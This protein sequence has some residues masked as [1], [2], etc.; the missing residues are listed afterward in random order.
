MET[1]DWMVIWTVTLKVSINHCFSE[2][3]VQMFPAHSERERLKTHISGVRIQSMLCSWLNRLF[4]L[5]GKALDR[6][7]FQ[8][9]Q[10]TSVDGSVWGPCAESAEK[11]VTWLNLNLDLDLHKNL[12]N[13]SAIK[14]KSAAWKKRSI[15]TEIMGLIGRSFL[16]CQ[17]RRTWSDSLI[18]GALSIKGAFQCGWGSF[19][20]MLFRNQSIFRAVYAAK[21]S[22]QSQAVKTKHPP[23]RHGLVTLL[24]R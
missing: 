20:S 5:C 17:C 15:S 19:H 22:S 18:A 24:P 13:K 16:Y 6:F 9:K 12:H 3:N 23:Q 10:H 14:T 21:N 2:H 11:P 4:S 8:N 7:R 1:A